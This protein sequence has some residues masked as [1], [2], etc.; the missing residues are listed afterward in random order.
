VNYIWFEAFAA[1]KSKKSSRATSRGW[2]PEKILLQTVNS[3]VTSVINILKPNGKK[4]NVPY[5]KCCIL[6]HV[7]PPIKIHK[8]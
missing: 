8:A 2:S 7:V 5:L 1:T 3:P 4:T 6:C